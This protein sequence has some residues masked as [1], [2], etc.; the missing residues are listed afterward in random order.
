MK[1]IPC[2]RVLRVALAAIA[3]LLVIACSATGQGISGTS[4][5]LMMRPSPSPQPPLTATAL[6]THTP[7]AGQAKIEEGWTEYSLP[8]DGF[9]VAL[10]QTW[11]K[12]DAGTDD[13]LAPAYI[14]Q[15]EHGLV[16]ASNLQ[17][18][19]DSLRSSDVRFLALDTAPE[20]VA[21]G[22]MTNLNV[23]H[24]SLVGNISL[25]EF[26]AGN[27]RELEKVKRVIKPVQ[28]Q[29]V[30]LPAGQALRLRYE[31]ELSSG[32]A[33][34]PRASLTQFLLINGQEGYVLTF[35]TTP[36]LLEKYKPIF[37]Q[38]GSSFRWLSPS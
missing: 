21:S 17:V 10:P 1:G 13:S 31:L 28:V 5:P 19:D 18:R 26:G 15:A 27:V 2:G 4:R 6:P 20:S 16:P 14:A 9:A 3:G 25:A 23:L 37:E 7:P 32:D 8:D 34:A 22:F 36:A 38:I 11:R 12:V 29:V 30:Q 24:R 35:A 33:Q